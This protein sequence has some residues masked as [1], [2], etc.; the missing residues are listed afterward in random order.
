MI[1]YAVAVDPAPSSNKRLEAMIATQS[2]GMLTTFNNTT[3]LAFPRFATSMGNTAVSIGPISFEFASGKDGLIS[4][5]YAGKKLSVKS[6][7]YPSMT[8]VF[9]AVETK[10]AANLPGDLDC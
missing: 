3:V 7:S 8:P 10:G 2:F 1:R 6:F 4:A 9:S 5:K